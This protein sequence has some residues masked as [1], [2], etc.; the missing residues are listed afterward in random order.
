MAVLVCFVW[1]LTVGAWVN[2]VNSQARN[3]RQRSLEDLW[4]LRSTIRLSLTTGSQFIDNSRFLWSAS[5][6]TD[7]VERLS[8]IDRGRKGWL[9]VL[10]DPNG[11]DCSIV[12]M[13]ILICIGEPQS[14]EYHSWTAVSRVARVSGAQ[15]TTY[16]NQRCKW[17]WRKHPMTD[18]IHVK[19]Q[20]VINVSF[21]PLLHL[22]SL[23]PSPPPP[24]L[25]G[26]CS[27]PQGAKGLI[28]LQYCYTYLSSHVWF[29]VHL[30]LCR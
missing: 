17:I 8:L 29:F 14:S 15:P 22:S 24:L 9:F 25:L 21:A 3:Y 19:H 2:A 18:V 4:S 5:I 1:Q 30:S 7:P 11:Y 26:S 6:A 23:S 28:M 20:T 13:E 10:S 27:A 16:E 12:V